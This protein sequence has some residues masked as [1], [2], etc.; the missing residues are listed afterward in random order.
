MTETTLVLDVAALRKIT[1]YANWMPA[2]RGISEECIAR[3]YPGWEWNEILPF[4]IKEKVVSREPGRS[5][6]VRLSQ[7]LSISREIKSVMIT[8][9]QNGFTLTINKVN[10]RNNR[11]NAGTTCSDGTNKQVRSQ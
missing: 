7:G 3:N 4:L 2:L 1:Q 9:T 11:E 10:I 8:R 6:S 5:H